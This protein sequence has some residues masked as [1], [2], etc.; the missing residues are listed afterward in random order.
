LAREIILFFRLI[1]IYDFIQI[2]FKIK[3]RKILFLMEI[4]N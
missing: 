3:I 2:V 1:Y 4:A